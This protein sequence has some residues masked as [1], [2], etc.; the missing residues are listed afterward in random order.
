MT[1]KL[2]V[3]SLQPRTGN[4]INLAGSG[5]VLH[6]PG[7]V[8]QTLSDET[9]SY[10]TY[11]SSAFTDIGLSVSITPSSSSNKVLV[12]YSVPVFV[13][14]TGSPA[15]GGGFRLY[16]DSTVIEDPQGD[17]S[18]ALGMWLNLQSFGSGA[19]Y[20]DYFTTHS[21]NVLDSPN[22]TAAITYSVKYSHRL[23]NNMRIGYN[24]SNYHP[25]GRMTVME[26]AQ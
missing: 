5:S 19:N 7:H 25:K 3:D 6:A 21:A 15:A 10:T 18:G 4:T 17:G 23:G 16:R 13:E 24:S 8:L 2:Y 11:T 20:W 12:I 26:I 22:T 9:S 1:S 14:G